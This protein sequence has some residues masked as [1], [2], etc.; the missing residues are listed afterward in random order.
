[1]LWSGI[2]FRGKAGQN[3]V[4]TE[5]MQSF[6]ELTDGNKG[7]LIASKGLHEYEILAEKRTMA[8]T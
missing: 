2:S 8:L 1:M 7:V 4:L 5:R 6:F 3:P